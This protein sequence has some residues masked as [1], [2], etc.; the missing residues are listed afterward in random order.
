MVNNT[1]EVKTKKNDKGS[2][3]KKIIV[4]LIVINIIL[5]GL[6]VVWYLYIRPWSIRDVAKAA[7]FKIEEDIEEPSELN[8][9]YSHDL[10]GK[11]K[12]IRGRITNI[13]SYMT[14]LGPLTY[15]ELDDFIYIR[16]IEW[17]YLK[18]KIG[19]EI[20]KKVNFEWSQWNEQKNVYSPQLDYPA[21][22]IAPA[23]EVVM[24]S[25]SYVQ[26]LILIAN[27]TSSEGP[28]NVSVNLPWDGGF[29]LELINCTLKAGTHSFAME[30]MDVSGGYKDNPTIDSIPS[31]F[32]DTGSNDIISFSDANQNRLFDDGDHF[33]FNLT[34]PKADSAILTYLF[35]INDGL[36][37]NE[38]K[39]V[40]GVC[41]I[42]MTNKGALRYVSTI[43]DGGIVSTHLTA[44]ILS[45]Y[46]TSEGIGTI[47]EIDNVIGETPNISDTLVYIPGDFIF[48]ESASL[49][50]GEIFNES[51]ITIFF[52]DT[53]DNWL[54]DN[55][56]RFT[57]EGLENNTRHELYIL[58]Q[59]NGER[60]AI[61]EWITGIGPISG[62]L[63][64]IEYNEPILI[65]ALDNNTYRI[66]IN[67][68]Y[69]IPGLNLVDEEREEWF[70]IQ[71]G[72][73]G[74]ELFPH[75]NITLNFTENIGGFNITFVDNDNNNFINSN[76]YFI[77]QVNNLGEYNLT[78][79]YVTQDRWDD[80]YQII[81]SR[82]V[83][84]T[85]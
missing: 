65:E 36:S 49:I 25:I 11:D 23:I 55:G 61:L 46:E 68:I 26:G 12:T 70:M 44:K 22:G 24:R 67:T 78:L 3:K 59:L 13:S 34:R 52:S 40:S 19:D 32:N 29:P 76:D 27:Q 33:T 43:N 83:S 42:I 38:Y 73:N 39:P 16:I 5:V 74:E 60:I 63:P 69:G 80:E 58:W 57:I 45:E 1:D 31:L 72:L 8:P 82:S 53:N 4:F 37:Y 75:S 2:K 54:L 50:E 18:Y 41:Y 20:E 35:S 84:W 14:T 7:G 85:V 15:Y 10:A 48:F 6:V 51:G 77:C 28:V 64:I 81:F 17:N 79:D 9:G 62:N 66:E 30:Y 47:I 71:M 56:D 21:I